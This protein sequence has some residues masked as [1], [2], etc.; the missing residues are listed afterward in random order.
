MSS[1]P[2]PPG[3]PGYPGSARGG[4]VEGEE[5]ASAA[6]ELGEEL[7]I[8]VE[9]PGEARWLLTHADG[10]GLVV[11]LFERWRGEPRNTAPREH[12]VIRWVSP[13]ELDGLEPAHPDY[14]HLL[15]QALT[16]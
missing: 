12:D 15:R 4:H 6:R 14:L 1:A 16:R 11:Y 13:G 5:S 3:V 8:E 10:A 2:D 9:P 7:G